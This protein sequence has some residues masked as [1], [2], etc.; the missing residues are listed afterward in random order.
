MRGLLFFLLLILAPAQAAEPP[1]L[2]IH[3]FRADG[4][5]HCD[6]AG[7]FFARL[8]A[9]E[10]RLA[11]RDYEVSRDPENRALF[12]AAL[13]ALK[14]EEGGVPFIFVGDWATLG[15]HTDAT[16]GAEIRRQVARCLASSCP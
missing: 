10:P 2:T 7:A 1:A 3:Y 14:V 4:C 16:T 15:Y 8:A 12:Q 11:V 9:E 6:D 5:P 13:D